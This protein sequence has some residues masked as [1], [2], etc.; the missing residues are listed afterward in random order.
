MLLLSIDFENVSA[1]SLFIAFKRQ[2]CLECIL[3]FEGFA[4][5]ID[6]LLRSDLL[7]SK[8]AWNINPNS[9]SNVQFLLPLFIT[10]LIVA[11]WLVSALTLPGKKIK[12]H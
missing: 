12:G 10:P 4:K 3:K 1:L 2:W 9:S 7:F 11:T 8:L 6:F 5:T